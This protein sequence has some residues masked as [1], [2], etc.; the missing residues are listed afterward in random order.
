MSKEKPTGFFSSV[1]ASNY[2]LLS[3]LSS[4]IEAA[5]SLESD[6]SDTDS[7]PQS[8]E[9]SCTGSPALSVDNHDVGATAR[10]FTQ[11]TKKY[12][13][14]VRAIGRKD[15]SVYGQP[16]CHLPLSPQLPKTHS[17]CSRDPSNE[18]LDTIDSGHGNGQSSPSGS[19][20]QPR[21]FD[22]FYVFRHSNSAGIGSE[23]DTFGNSPC[24]SVDSSDTESI[25]EGRSLGIGIS[26]SD[27]SLHSWTSSIS[28][29]SRADDINNEA[30]KFMKSYVQNIFFSSSSITFEEKAK[31]G[32]LCQYEAG[33]L[34][35]AR[36]V[37]GQRVHNKRVTESTFYSL[38]QHFAIVLFECGESDDFSPAK[39]L[40]NMC[41]T[42]FHEVSQ[43]NSP[44][45]KEYL[46]KYL[47]EQPIWHSLHFWNAAFFDAVQKE[48]SLRPMPTRKEMNHL[49]LEDI[50]DE[51]SFQ[52]NITFGQLGTFTHNMHAFGLSKALCLEFLRKQSTIANLPS[53]QVQLLQENIERIYQDRGR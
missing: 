27:G 9:T 50:R 48:R 24:T 3:G 46:Y 49:S 39:S 41:L 32:E 2:G 43:G 37:N 5:L 53:E 38:V 22:P 25:P 52:E 31:F 35:F 47:K 14:K 28:C 1:F 20:E 10:Q 42:F 29:D 4:K 18:S 15:R 17:I 51:T 36:C 11:E 12:S 30:M 13:K 45:T 19:N 7:L 26:G 34:W 33:R 16:I 23:S 21:K 6:G 44:P 40:M 8:S